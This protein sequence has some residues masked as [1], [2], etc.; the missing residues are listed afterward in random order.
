MLQL[1]K[2]AGNELNKL[3]HAS[4]IALAN[5]DQPPLYSTQSFTSPSRVSRQK[6]SRQSIAIEDLSSFFHISIAWRLTAPTATDQNSVRA[7]KLASLASKTIAF[8]TVKI[9]IGNAIE[10][11]EL[12]SKPTI[13]KGLFGG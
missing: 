8:S 4:N 1:E 11:I 2:P 6:Q 9:K 3:L 13:A 12:V 7:F 5:F 10:N